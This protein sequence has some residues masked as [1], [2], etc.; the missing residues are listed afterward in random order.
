M[1]KKYFGLLIGLLVLMGTNCPARAA[2]TN[3]S[4]I[5]CVFGDSY[6]RNHRCPWQETW[7]YKAAQNLGLKYINLG[8]NGSAISF[9]NKG[10]GPAMTDRIKTE[11]PDKMDI[12]MIVAGH[13]DASK[14]GAD[15]DLTGF[16]SSLSTIIDEVR[17]RYPE[18]TVAYVLPWHVDRGSF[19]SVIEIIKEVCADKKVPVFD[20]E[21]A[22]GIEVN[23]ID[24]RRKYFQDGGEKDTAHL[25]DAG[26]N[27]IVDAG[28]KFISSLLS[29]D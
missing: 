7:H 25:N 26:H 6:V 29:S 13:N 1:M 22:G 3:D 11:L 9:A 14:L 18:T 10:F 16:R 17:E 4:T 24:F 21:T 28:T 27:L 20:A 19:T 5:I 2:E 12:F 23:N 15:E 8:R